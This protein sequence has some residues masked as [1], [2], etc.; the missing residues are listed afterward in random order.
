MSRWQ[1]CRDTT[2]RD[3]FLGRAAT[4]EFKVQEREAGVWSFDPLS[5]R[6]SGEMGTESERAS[7]E[8]RRRA[9]GKANS[10][11]TNEKVSRKSDASKLAR[12]WCATKGVKDGKSELL[13]YVKK[14][15][16]KRERERETVHRREVCVLGRKGWKRRRGW[17]ARF[18]CVVET[19]WKATGK[20]FK[21]ILEKVASSFAVIDARWKTS[22]FLRAFP[23][24]WKQKERRSNVKRNPDQESFYIIFS[25]FLSL[26]LF[27]FL[28]LSSSPLP[29]Y[30]LR[31]KGA[32]I[33]FYV[34]WLDGSS[35]RGFAVHVKR[36]DYKAEFHRWSHLSRIRA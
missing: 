36:D 2:S 15:G 35:L 19:D 20:K 16:R 7:G 22:L 3:V 12:L 1:S 11:L 32:I 14:S 28:F 26:S 24:R 13:R 29:F 25:L 10:N 17:K 23:K 9:G 30:S 8:R 31:L 33:A 21:G 6:R 34:L 18:L 27:S 4:M 5:R